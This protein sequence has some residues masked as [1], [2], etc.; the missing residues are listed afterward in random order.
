MNAKQ[1]MEAL[2]RPFDGDVVKWRAQGK[3]YKRGDR[4]FARVVAYVDARIV[5]DRLNDVMGFDWQKRVTET[6]KGRVI[7]SLG[8]TIDGREVWRDDG[9]GDTQIE[10]EKGAI[11]DALKRA[12]VNF[13]VGK[14]LYELPTPSV[15][16]E[17]DEKGDK[18]FL[19]GLT[20]ESRQRLA[21]LAQRSLD[22]WEAELKS[23]DAGDEDEAP[24][25][26]QASPP[27]PPPPA[28][29][30]ADKKRADAPK[31]DAPKP[32]ARR[33]AQGKGGR[34]FEAP[35]E[36]TTEAWREWSRPLMA[37]IKAES[38]GEAA[39]KHIAAN[40]TELAQAKA[41]TGKDTRA[42]IIEATFAKRWPDFEV[43]SAPAAAGASRKDQPKP[44]PE[45]LVFELPKKNT[46]ATMD[47]W[48][49]KLLSFIEKNA[50]T[51][52]QAEEIIAANRH[53]LALASTHFKSDAEE[54]MR[55]LAEDLFKPTQQ[56]GA[57][58]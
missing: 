57:A 25:N 9:A 33:A 43:P 47:A 12:A 52:A 32:E 19:K 56:K 2:S 20:R 21:S 18:V 36:R 45:A 10:G 5:I 49:G 27:P 26:S 4:H 15:E 50:E 35:K 8:L 37:A 7:C 1:I 55:G 39:F 48:C 44:G 29:D 42:L 11:S 30:A 31:D 51:M 54:T 3:P 41:D 23:M 13:G 34:H 6:A 46:H 17:C 24:Q 16:V 40:E 22:Q 53:G 14:Y 38:S 28:R 58:R